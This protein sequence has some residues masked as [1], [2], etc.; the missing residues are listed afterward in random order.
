M[1]RLP[2]DAASL[3]TGEELRSVHIRTL[4]E[5]MALKA[6]NATLKAA[7]LPAKKLPDRYKQEELDSLYVE[8][9]RQIE[10]LEKEVAELREALKRARMKNDGEVS[11]AREAEK[12][13]QRQLEQLRAKSTQQA[14]AAATELDRVRSAYAAE[15][16]TKETELS[17]ASDAARSVQL[18]LTDEQL[19]GRA[20]QAE[21]DVARR[22]LEAQGPSEDS[23]CMAVDEERRRAAH[24]L[25]SAQLDATRDAARAAEAR[26][27]AAE[28]ELAKARAQGCARKAAAEAAEAEL[29]R[30]RSSLEAA[31]AAFAA[32]AKRREQLEAATGRAEK[33]RA[34]AAAKS[35]LYRDE[36]ACAREQAAAAARGEIERLR[37]ELA[38]AHAQLRQLQL[39]PAPQADE[40]STFTE[41]V[42]LRRELAVHKSANANLSR[43]ALAGPRLSLHGLDCPTLPRPAAPLPTPA[44]HC[45]ALPNLPRCDLGRRQ[46]AQSSGR[47]PKRTDI[48]FP[49][50]ER[51]APQHERC[52]PPPEPLATIIS[53]HT[54]TSRDARGAGFA[55]TLGV[56]PQ[57][58]HSVPVSASVLR[59]RPASASRSRV[60][61]VAVPSEITATAACSAGTESETDR[62]LLRRP[63][64]AS[65]GPSTGARRRSR[66]LIQRTGLA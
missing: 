28:A 50:A 5:V 20:L 34:E 3:P 11:A 18:E 65:R 39:A 27:A 52:A 6:E 7:A 30:V 36:L 24:E 51:P 22:Q 2:V 31:E 55:C 61:P 35:A 42:E 45:P 53:R 56:G 13:L 33:L 54:S 19:R 12:R 47:R 58:Q 25:T 8:E 44:R 38:E 17:T 37:G 15:L 59:T 66:E 21:L 32:E 46:L 29:G 62:M 41:F 48:Q 16:E 43:C 49:E 26:A 10:S 23:A 57:P 64:S 60:S 63:P 9:R 40:R 14:A 4:H 1:V